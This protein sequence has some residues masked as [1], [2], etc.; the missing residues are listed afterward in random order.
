MSNQCKSKDG[1]HDVLTRQDDS[2]GIWEECT[3]CGDQIKIRKDPA[4]RLLDNETYYDFH[5]KDF[6]SA[7]T[8]A[9]ERVYGKQKAQEN[10]DFRIAQA[11]KKEEERLWK[12]DLQDAK[13]W[14]NRKKK[15]T[16]DY[17]I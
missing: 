8:E 9:F 6:L 4:G 14:A 16:K 12:E 10:I 2:Y 11:K 13:E 1:Y 5:Q 7:G 17:A 3:V 15:G